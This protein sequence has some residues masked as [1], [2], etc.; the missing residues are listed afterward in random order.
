MAEKA[1][2]QEWCDATFDSAGSKYAADHRIKTLEEQFLQDQ[3][4]HNYDLDLYRQ[5]D[6]IF[7]LLTDEDVSNGAAENRACH[8]SLS[9]LHQLQCGHLVVSDHV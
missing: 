1:R 8:D 2:I 9:R 3:P 7:K 5:Y 4:D 6:S